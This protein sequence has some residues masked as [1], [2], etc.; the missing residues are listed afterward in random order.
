MAENGYGPKAPPWTA[1][2]YILAYGSNLDL[3]RIKS[4]CPGST[5][6]G[7]A[8]IP[9]YRLLFKQSFSGSY[10]TVEQD[11]NWSVPAVVYQVGWQDE[12]RLDRFEGCP[13]ASPSS[14]Q[15]RGGG[16]KAQG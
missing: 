10:A 15:D 14:V 7:T 11:A 6:V 13:R 16:R 5:L 9:G 2:R 12:Q 4:R 1:P 3:D 8:W